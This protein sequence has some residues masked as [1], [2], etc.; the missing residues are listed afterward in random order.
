M[1]YTPAPCAGIATLIW[2]CRIEDCQVCGN[3][4]CLDIS[5]LI[6]KPL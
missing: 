6:P 4:D 5:G 2:D 1:I 3:E